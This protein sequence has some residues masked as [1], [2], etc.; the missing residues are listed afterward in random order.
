MFLILAAPFYILNKS[1]Q[2]FQFPHMLDSTC[3][4]VLFFVLFW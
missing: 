2:R 1:A 4:F 3:F